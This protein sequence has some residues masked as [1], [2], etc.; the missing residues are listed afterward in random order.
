MKAKKRKKITKA[1]LVDLEKKRQRRLNREDREF[2][3]FLKRVSEKGREDNKRIEEERRL[4][5]ELWLDS[6][7]DPCGFKASAMFRS[8]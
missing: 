8:G 7:S 1:A 5:H 6:F 4:N 3:E 2:K